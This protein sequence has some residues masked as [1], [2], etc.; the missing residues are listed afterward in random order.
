MKAM[1]LTGPD[2]VQVALAINHSNEENLPNE[3]DTSRMTWRVVSSFRARSVASRRPDDIRLKFNPR[4]ALESLVGCPLQG[5]SWPALANEAE[6]ERW[7]TTE[8]SKLA[9]F[10]LLVERLRGG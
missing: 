7:R 5:G 9:A 8:P 2:A 10:D 4:I 3:A 6:L 1:I